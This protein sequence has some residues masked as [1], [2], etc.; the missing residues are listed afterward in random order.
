MIVLERS[1]GWAA[2]DHLAPSRPISHN[3][4]STLL[5]SSGNDPS[6][7]SAQRATVTTDPNRRVGL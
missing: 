1:E 2:T 6:A 7:Y 4:A 5:I 3:G